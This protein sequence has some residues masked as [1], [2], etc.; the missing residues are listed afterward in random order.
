M[1]INKSAHTR[2]GILDQCFS[3]FSRQYSFNDLK[4]EIE[5][6]LRDKVDSHKMTISVRQLRADI[7]YMESE[8]G[9]SISLDRI[10]KGRKTYYRYSDPYYSIS[11]A[12]INKRDLSAL[13]SIIDI[14]SR[15]KGLDNFEW[16]LDIITKLNHNIYQIPG[17]E[18]IISFDTNLDLEGKE[19][20]QNIFNFIINKTVIKVL[21]KPFEG[22]ENLEFIIHPYFLKEFN[23]R[24]FLIGY[25][26]EK[27]SYTWIL[28]IDRIQSIE[29][30]IN[31]K[32]LENKII[33]WEEYFSDIIGVTNYQNEVLEEI[34]LN[35][36]KKLANYILTKPIHQS[37]KFKW[38]NN[39]KL[40][41]RIQVKINIELENLI[42]SF[43][44]NCSVINPI[45]LRT[46]LK[47]RILKMS[48]NY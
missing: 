33:N 9:Y 6:Q 37:Q 20:V 35:F 30:L 12:P 13:K 2:Y 11:K 32:Y 34:K 14:L 47:E 36:D 4:N 16:I 21:Y 38:L 26:E 40:E 41:I 31:K 1:P 43:G 25:N 42:L 28:A 5:I 46:K 15:F 24:W 48:Q 27:K 22:D 29:E 23:N 7:K 10:K 19:F 44:E 8:A 17:N 39:E 45:K 3:N 18:P